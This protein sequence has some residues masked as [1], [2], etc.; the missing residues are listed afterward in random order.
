[1]EF[2]FLEA[3]AKTPIILVEQNQFIQENVFNNAPDRQ[4]AITM[5][6]NSAFTGSYTENPFWI[7]QFDLIQIKIL[8]GGQSIV[9]FDAADKCRLCVTTMKAMNFQGDI[10]PILS[11]NF[12]ELFVLAFV[13][14]S[15]HDATEKF[16]YLV[17]V[18]EPLRLALKFSFPVEH[19]TELIVL[20][21]RIS[22][23]AVNKFGVDG[24]NIWK[25]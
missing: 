24:K 10:P 20:G 1:M 11:G 4:I 9:Q 3:L 7:Q 25:R 18:R 17:L 23:V 22:S 19:V 12:K 14:T 8:R 16:R 5:N 2:N 15:I 21:E 13:L 6:T